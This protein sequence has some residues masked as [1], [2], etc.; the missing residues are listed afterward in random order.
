M[1]GLRF[2]TITVDQVQ[3]IMDRFYN[4]PRKTLGYQTPNEVFFKGEIHQGA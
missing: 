1:H 3:W 4:R 2:E